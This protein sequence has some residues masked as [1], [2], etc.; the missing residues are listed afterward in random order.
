MKKILVR[1]LKEERGQALVERA[2]IAALFTLA[3]LASTKYV[4][5]GLVSFYGYVTGMICLPIP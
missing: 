3:I 5:D 4:I 1:F 2:V